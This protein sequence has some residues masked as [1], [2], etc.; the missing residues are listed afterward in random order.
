MRQLPLSLLLAASTAACLD[1]SAT[2]TASQVASDLD[3]DNG[4]ATTADEAPMFA[5]QVAFDAMGIEADAAVTDTMT[6]DPTVTALT[7][8]PTL[9]SRRV[10]VI[11]GRMPADP[12][13]VDGRDWSGS[14]ALSR[15]GMLVGRTVG[16][17]PATDRVLP[18]QTRDRVAFTSVTRPAADGLVLRVL[19]DAASTDPLTLTY[20]SAVDASITYQF[21]LAQLAAGPIAIDAGDGNQMVAIALRDHDAC[22]HGFM[23]G[24]W[25]Q[26]AAHMGVYR[27]IV[28]GADGTPIGHVRGIYGQ[29][30]SGEKVV[31]GK[32]IDRDGKFVGLISG[33]YDNG[34]FRAR[35]IDRAGDRGKIHGHYFE[36]ATDRAGGFVARWAE[37]SCTED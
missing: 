14:L 15:G 1:N 16:F 6:Q 32:F 34:E 12:D 3:K 5:D 31:F 30:K 8:L 21:D 24:R 28:H 11:W 19:A 13:A 17:E 22:E 4:G 2:D 35:W 29:R 7:A 37:N 36:G 9:D 27:G 23:R 33:T 18:R 26:L 20:T 10:L 25:H